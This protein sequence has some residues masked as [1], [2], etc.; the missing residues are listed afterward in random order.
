MHF[1]DSHHNR[2]V[3][4]L[5]SAPLKGPVVIRRRLDYDVF[6]LSVLLPF[7]QNSDSAK[8]YADMGGT[9]AWLLINHQLNGLSTAL[10]KH[11]FWP[12]NSRFSSYFTLKDNGYDINVKCEMAK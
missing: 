5:Y 3:L 10:P 9:G 8:I 7:M 11:N 6:S 4:S 12:I 2:T 1:N